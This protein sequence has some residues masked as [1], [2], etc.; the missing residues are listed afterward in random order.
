MCISELWPLY[1]LVCPNHVT[2]LTSELSHV[3]GW[4]VRGGGG[5][6]TG[7]DSDT[8][9]KAELNSEVAAVLL[10][11]SFNTLTELCRHF[12]PGCL[13][14]SDTNKNH[15]NMESRGVARSR[16]RTVKPVLELMGSSSRLF[17]RLLWL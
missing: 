10:E 6:E 9:A 4:G 5:G 12:C 14:Q 16:W 7:P 1:W 2:C 11:P 3:E 13:T 17:F 15:Q 8:R